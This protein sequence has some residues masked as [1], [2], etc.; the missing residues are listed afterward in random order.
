MTDIIRQ[1]EQAGR[2]AGDVIRS[3][4]GRDLHIENKEGHANFVTMYDKKVQDFLTERLGEILPGAKFLG[5]ENGLDVFRPGDEEGWL[6][7]IDPIDGTTN[8]IH[9]M[10]PYVTSIGLM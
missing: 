10:H 4:H 7:V 9:N 2:E 8:F 6:F 3:A 1:I 5:E